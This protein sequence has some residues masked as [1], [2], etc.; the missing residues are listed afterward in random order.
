MSDIQY[1]SP[2][3]RHA[4]DVATVSAGPTIESN[5][6][7]D[8]VASVNGLLSRVAALEAA[9][10]ADKEPGEAPSTEVLPNKPGGF[11]LDSTP[12]GVEYHSNLPAPEPARITY[13]APPAEV[14]KD[15]PSTGLVTA[16]GDG[17]SSA[18][19]TEAPKE[20]PSASTGNPTTSGDGS[21]AT[22]TVEVAG[23]TLP[24]DTPGWVRDMIAKGQTLGNEI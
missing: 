17:T 2:V 4:T 16:P 22:E 1:T 18:S 10:F 15:A 19:T 23:H 20:D 12:P 24:A 14:P 9:V 21:S 11:M 7:G 3:E 13:A 8:V 5:V 6:S